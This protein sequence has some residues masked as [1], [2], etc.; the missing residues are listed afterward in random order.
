MTLGPQF[1]DEMKRL[2]RPLR[3]LIAQYLGTRVSEKKQG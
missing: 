2:N 1:D 3:S